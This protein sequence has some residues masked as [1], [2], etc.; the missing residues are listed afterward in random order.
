MI[1]LIC[2]YIYTYTWQ[3]QGQTASSSWETV[4]LDTTLRLGP[5]CLRP[6][7]YRD[8]LRKST[9]DGIGLT[10]FYSSTRN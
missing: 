10:A 5:V 9:L 8:Q 4:A 3:V 6:G 2:I 7:T 1:M